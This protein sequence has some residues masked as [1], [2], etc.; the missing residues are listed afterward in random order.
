[1]KTVSRRRFLKGAVTSGALAG[2]GTWVGKGPQILAQ[3]PARAPLHDAQPFA[4]LRG[5]VG[6]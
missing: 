1:M 3:G 4:G 6:E 5:K 2:L